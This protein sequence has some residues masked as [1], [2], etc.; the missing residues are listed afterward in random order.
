[1]EEVSR[2]Y[3][4][5]LEDALN[6]LRER[7][8]EWLCTGDDCSPFDHGRDEGLEI[9][10]RSIASIKPLKTEQCAKC[11]YMLP[12]AYGRCPLCPEGAK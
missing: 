8:R 10:I 3:K 12:R 7:Q 2:D 9:A 6:L 5:A 1:M 11:P 4:K